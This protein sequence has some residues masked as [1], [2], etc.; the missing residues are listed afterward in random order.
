MGARFQAARRAFL[1]TGFNVL[2]T[3]VLGITGQVARVL[4][5]AFSIQLLE[6]I[7]GTFRPAVGL[8]PT[9]IG[10]RQLA[11]STL[12]TITFIWLWTFN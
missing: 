8:R 9:A 6:T 10:F 7:W 12:F 3:I 4:W 11:V 1:Y 5:L 2:F